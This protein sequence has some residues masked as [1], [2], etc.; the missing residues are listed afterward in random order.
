MIKLMA[1]AGVLPEDE[2]AQ[3]AMGT[4]LGIMRT[5]ASNDMKLKAARTV[6]EYTKAKPTSKAELTVKTAEDFL[7]ELAEKDEPD[8]E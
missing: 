4:V 1:E 7:D 8:T 3:E 6:L 5:T 2:G